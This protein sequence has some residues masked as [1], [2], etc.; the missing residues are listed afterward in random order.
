MRTINISSELTLLV[1]YILPAALLGILVP[2]FIFLFSG[3]SVDYSGAI[4]IWGARLLLLSFGLSTFALLRFTIFKLM[5]V[6][7]DASH[8]YIS[9]YFKH[10]RYT[11]DSIE[12][13]EDDIILIFHIPKIVLKD[14]GIF[15][16][17][18][19]FWAGGHFQEVV[20]ESEALSAL[21]VRK[22]S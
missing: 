5:R 4:P 8:L 16:K 19:R 22:S 6:E 18:I 15:G 3:S 13:I 10:A 9:N 2:F 14:A 20:E 11:Y 21:I 12:R 17:E 1:R 7:V